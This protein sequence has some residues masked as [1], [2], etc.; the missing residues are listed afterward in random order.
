ME[1][2]GAAPGWGVRFR[3]ASRSP[4]GADDGQARLTHCMARKPSS[5]GK[6][7]S[8]GK[9][10]RQPEAKKQK[11]GGFRDRRAPPAALVKAAAGGADGHR[12]RTP[13]Q[14]HICVPRRESAARNC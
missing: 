5:D 10:P 14:G 9:R 7:L 8:K 6:E 13:N 3:A 4:K 2:L 12:S 11:G 1:S